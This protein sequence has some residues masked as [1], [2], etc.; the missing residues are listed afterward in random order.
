MGP[1]CSDGGFCPP[2]RCTDL[3]VGLPPPIFAASRSIADFATA[4]VDEVESEEHA[5]GRWSVTGFLEDDTPTL[6]YVTI[7]CPVLK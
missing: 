7:D 6:S 3:E 2:W 4:I 1:S 5:I